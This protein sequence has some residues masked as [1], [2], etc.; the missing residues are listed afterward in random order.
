MHRGEYFCSLFQR[1]N[2]AVELGFSIALYMH[3]WEL[4][5]S[6]CLSLLFN[7]WLNMTCQKHKWQHGNKTKTISVDISC[8]Q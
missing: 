6:P 8:K 3:L 5:R 7:P 2:L 4:S 1:P